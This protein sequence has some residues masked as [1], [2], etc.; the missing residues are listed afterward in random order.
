MTD[1]MDGELLADQP[2]GHKLI[3]KG[4]WLYF[5]MIFTAPVGYLIKVIVSNSL[6]VEDIGIF[7]SVLG[8]IMLVSTYHDLGLTEALK[9]F[10]P[11]YRIEKKYDEYKTTI[12]WTLITQVIIGTI[13][14]IAIYFGADRLAIHHFRSIEAVQI[15]KTLARYFIGVNFISVFLS[16]YTAFQDT[17]AY[18]ILEAARLYITLWFTLFFRLTSTLTVDNFSIAWITGILV[19]MAITGIIFFKK[20]WH[21]LTKGKIV[22]SPVLIKTQL[23]YAFRVFLWI[24]I[25]SLLGLVDQQIVINLLW[26]KDAGYYSNYFSLLT[27]YSII[28]SPLLLRVFPIV[29]ELITKN[30][31]HQLKMLQDILY[32]YFSVF[33]LSIGWLFA[34]FG[35]E[36]AIVLFGTKF[37]YSWELLVYSWPFLIINVLY[38]INFAILAWLGKVRAR[39]KILWIALLLNVLI[40]IALLYVFKIGLPGAVIAMIIWRV[41]L[42]WWSLNIIQ[43][44]LKISFDR[45]F[46]IKNLAIIS[47]CSGALFLV[48]ERFLIIDDT[49]RWNNIWYLLVAM[50]L[51]YMIL[52]GVNHKSIRML[53]KEIKSIKR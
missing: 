26:P 45:L 48:K 23:K 36:I 51:Y 6:S 4:F 38:I 16:V 7:Y 50:L 32:K 47:L 14:A 27:T 41:I 52:V 34:I 17:I 40:N 30:Q 2:L 3:K 18:S 39:V 19:G 35:K 53:V 10:L 24:N 21:T 37:L 9:Y 1:F 25:G 12:I 49:A 28:I 22:F 11:K 15:I 31:M 29:T 8:F 5:F 13:I 33:A 20:Y 42:W 43:K 46:F 44:N